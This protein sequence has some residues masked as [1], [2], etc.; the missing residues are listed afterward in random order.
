MIYLLWV[1]PECP[2]HNY[3]ASCG[4]VCKT[5]APLPSGKQS[6][7]HALDVSWGH[8]SRPSQHILL[9]GLSGAMRPLL[10]YSML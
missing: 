3:A 1:S 7:R 9:E 8:G 6:T 10:G 5:F 4:Q 2:S